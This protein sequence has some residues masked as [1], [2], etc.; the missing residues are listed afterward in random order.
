MFDI[1]SWDNKRSFLI[2]EN[3]FLLFTK[4]YLLDYYNIFI[5]IEANFEPPNR[6]LDGRPNATKSPYVLILFIGLIKKDS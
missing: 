1:Q 5:K 6:P 2:C 3:G 4:N